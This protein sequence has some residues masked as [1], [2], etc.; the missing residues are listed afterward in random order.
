MEIK[1]F[2][3]TWGL[4]YLSYEEQFRKISEAGYDGVET[5]RI[6]SGEIDQV[7]A[8]LEKYN[9]LLI[10]QQ[11]T[12][13]KTA[14]EH[15]ESF[16]RQAELNVKLKPV[17]INSHTGKDHFGT[18]HNLKIL[19]AI[20]NYEET[21]EVPIFHETHRG[22]FAFASHVTSD[23]LEIMPNLKLTAD[24][25]H[26][27]CVAES[28]LE[29]QEQ[30][31]KKLFGNCRQIHARLGNTQSPQVNDPQS[32]EWEAERGI[33]LK[34]WKQ[35]LSLENDTKGIFP[36]TCEFGPW[37]YMPTAPFSAEPTCSQWDANLFMKK[38]LGENLP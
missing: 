16:I 29:D 34:W 15:V 37:P 21:A 30:R 32:P 1:F 26:W 25:S 4:E 22:R 9:L 5:G 12:E 33:F 31:L 35:I 10:C 20:R 13:G 7:L 19:K 28:Y 18:L 27:C 38:W 2:A 23:Y 14:G 24:L 6:K 8:L 3:T 17:A 36:I 11:W